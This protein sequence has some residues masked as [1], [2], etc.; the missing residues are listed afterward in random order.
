MINKLKNRRMQCFLVLA[1][2]LF[3]QMVMHM[4]VDSIFQDDW[5]FM[6]ALNDQN[7]AQYLAGRWNTWSSRLVIE[8][9]LA[10]LTHS[11][12]AFRVLDSLA[13]VLLAYSLCRLAGCEER[14][15]MMMLAACLVTT[16]PFAILRSTGWMATSLNYYWPLACTAGA[17][18]PLADALWRRKTSRIWQVAAVLL[19]IYGANQEQ[20]SAVIAGGSLVFGAALYIRDKAVSPAI[21][22]VFFIGALQLVMHLTCPGNAIRAEQSVAVVNLRDY[23]QFS[24][25]DKL[26]IGL[27]G[28]TALM[29]YTYNPMLLCCGA[30]VGATITARR[31][32]VAAHLL[33]LTASPFVLRAFLAYFTQKMSSLAGVNSLFLS[34]YSYALR[35]GPEGIGELGRMIMMFMTIFVLGLMALALYLSI[36]HR[37]LSAAAVMIFAIGFA[38]RMALSFSPTVVESGERTMLPLY[39]AMML[40]ALLCVRDCR[41]ENARRWPLWIAGMIVIAVTALNVLGSFALAA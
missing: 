10:V 7:M 20:T 28:T 2:M 19:A 39:G 34:M 24:L 22:A 35:L 13:M 4:N 37:P 40:C 6:N 8:S 3:I 5:V 14:P 27:T 16:I 17:L 36:G 9:V 1:G 33:V 41:T 12:W 32:G 21:A 26:S 23:A 15:G 38:A 29:I 30:L 31:R 25:V 11:I 18:I